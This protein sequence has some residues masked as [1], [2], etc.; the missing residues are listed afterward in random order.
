[1]NYQLSRTVIAASLLLAFGSSYAAEPAQESNVFKSAKLMLPVAAAKR[2]Q[3]VVA[4]S[5]AKIWMTSTVKPWLMHST[6]YLA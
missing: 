2:P 6:C 3:S 5:L 4:A 1:M